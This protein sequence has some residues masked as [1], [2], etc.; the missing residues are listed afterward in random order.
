VYLCLRYFGGRGL[1][2]WLVT[3]FGV[4]TLREFYAMLERMGLNPFDRLG[5]TLGRRSCSPPAISSLTAQTEV[6]LALTVVVFSVR[7]LGEREPH[8]RVETLAWSLFGVVYVP[9]MLQF[10]VRVL[11]IDAPHE[12]TGL[13]LALWLIAVSKFC[14]TGALLTA[15]PSAGTRWRPTSAR[16]RPG[17]ARPAASLT[18][19]RRRRRLAWGCQRYL[20]PATLHALVGAVVALPIA[21]ARDRVRPHRVHHQTPRRHQGRRPDHPRHRRR[22]RPPT[23]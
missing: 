7:I 14:D 6:L 13:V 12:Q 16:R 9:F 3:L 18:S 19:A 15:S 20:P 5:L 21:G 22:V 17:R 10:L 2:S 4:L 1:A 23:A 11:L 8:N